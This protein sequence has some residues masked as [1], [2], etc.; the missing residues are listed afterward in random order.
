MKRKRREKLVLVQQSEN[1]DTFQCAGCVR[2]RG[3]KDR[4]NAA[5][6]VRYA[7]RKKAEAAAE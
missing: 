1:E 4:K 5:A 3:A 6:R 7:K 2:R